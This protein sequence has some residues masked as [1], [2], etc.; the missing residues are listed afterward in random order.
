MLSNGW[1][2]KLVYQQ[3]FLLGKN[4]NSSFWT[5]R[6][7]QVSLLRKEE[8]K[9]EDYIWSFDDIKKLTLK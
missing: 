4:G 5:K 3:N 6:S 1:E 2:L 9:F 7:D 8:L